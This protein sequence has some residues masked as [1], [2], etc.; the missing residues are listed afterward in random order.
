MTYNLLEADHD[1]VD[2]A[3]RF[4]QYVHIPLCIEILWSPDPDSFLL[5]FGSMNIKYPG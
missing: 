2:L 4:G 3:F 1:C 5:R